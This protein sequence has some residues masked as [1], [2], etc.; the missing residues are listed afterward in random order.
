MSIDTCRCGR[1]VDTDDEPEAYSVETEDGEVIQLDYCLCESCRMDFQGLL[2]LKK[3]TEEFSNY[4]FDWVS[5]LG[6]IPMLDRMREF[7]G[8]I[9]AMTDTKRAA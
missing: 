9:E 5:T 7:R 3:K 6:E 2:E 1:F 4:I 8:K